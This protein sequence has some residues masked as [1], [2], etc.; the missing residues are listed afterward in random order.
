MAIEQNNHARQS[1]LIVAEPALMRSMLHDLLQ[2]A[3]PT[4]T[5][6]QTINGRRALELCALHRPQLVLMATDLPDAG[7]IELTALLK[8]WY[9]EIKVIIVSAPDD[10]FPVEQ[11]HAAGAIAWITQDMIHQELLPRVAS[12]L[13]LAP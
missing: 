1:V 11:A 8:A 12:A 6:R 9:P 2:R 4:L 5:L 3:F 13:G 7:S 10:D